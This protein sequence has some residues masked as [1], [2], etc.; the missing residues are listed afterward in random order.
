[1][2]KTLL[3]LLLL[4]PF[5]LLRAQAPVVDKW[6]LFIEYAGLSN[7]DL[8]QT[9]PH[10]PDMSKFDFKNEENI[11]DFTEKRLKWQTKYPE[12]VNAFLQMDRVK[13]LNPSWVDLGL[14]K[15]G[16]DIQKFEHGYYNWFKASGLTVA[17][18]QS[19]APHFPTNITDGTVEQQEKI[20]DEAV[21]D[22]MRIFISEYEA[23]LNN[24][25]LTKLNKYYDEK[26]SIEANDEDAYKRLQPTS[27][28]PNVQDFQ[29]NN[30]ELDKA[31][32][33]AYLKAW[34]YRYSPDEYYQ[35]YEPQN[36][37]KY[38]EYKQYKEEHPNDK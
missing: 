33:E 17:Q 12:E 1:M 25:A 4:I 30:P 32:F 23:F 29:S 26:V 22:W 27:E 19:F 11:K 7:E 21:Q 8:H 31:R 24:P 28:Q 35:I 13:N 20:Y 10:F 16:E 6:Q 18:L 2:K 34:Y 38:Q 3:S 14:K 15:E 36:Y 5:C 9:C 37:D